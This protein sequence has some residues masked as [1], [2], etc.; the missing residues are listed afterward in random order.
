L[1]IVRWRFLLLLLLLLLLQFL[2]KFL[3]LGCIFWLHL[4]VGN[5]KYGA[6]MNLNYHFFKISERFVKCFPFLR[7]TKQLYMHCYVS[8][9]CN[10][11]TN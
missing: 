8:Q 7:L 1:V 5:R 11:A 3:L 4:L 9:S 6:A 2:G 10:N